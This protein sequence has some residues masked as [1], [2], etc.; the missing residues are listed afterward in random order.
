[1]MKNLVQLDSEYRCRKIDVSSGPAVIYFESVSGCPFTCVM[2]PTTARKAY[3]APQ[4]LLRRVEPAFPGL[5][6]LAIHGD[7]EPLLGDLEYFVAQSSK[8]DFV[9]HMNTTGLL[10]TDE[11]ADLLLKMRLSIRFSIHAGRPETYRRIMGSDFEKVRAR[12][13]R[14]IEKADGSS[15][16][17]DFWFSYIVMKENLGEIEDFLR[18][19]HGCGIRNVRFMSLDPNKETRKGVTIRGMTFKHL[20][21]TNKALHREFMSR[22]GCYR[23]L[24]AEL[25]IM[26]ERGSIDDG[27]ATAT[28]LGELANR[29]SC[30]LMGKEFFPIIRPRSGCAAPWI[31]QLIV[32][33][34]GDVR[35]CCVLPQ[36]VG[37]IYESTLEDIWH[38]PTM[39]QI[40][41]TFNKGGSPRI[42][43]YCR[44]FG[45]DNYPNNAFVGSG[46]RS[47]N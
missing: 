39:T 33:I 27:R 25:G 43:G 14:F 21:Q 5:E 16:K 40:R 47:Q 36:V 15:N 26:I 1:M 4:E 30:R 13:T 6:V 29:A 12:I 19:A 46:I 8:H 24:A 23:A 18:F 9:L 17:H 10:L 45:Y 2:C 28:K 42:C 41:S 44:G 11:I 32:T 31:G 35:L 3:R 20:D 34:N 7:G 38:G 22:M 37:N